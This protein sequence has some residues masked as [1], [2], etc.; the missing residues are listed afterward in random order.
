MKKGK[1]IL[2]IL[3]F[4]IVE[5][6]VSSRVFCQQK[7]VK[8]IYQLQSIFIYNFAKLVGWPSEELQGNFIIV[9]YGNTPLTDDLMLLSKSKKIEKLTIVVKK[10]N[11][12]QLLTKCHI[13]FVSKNAMDDFDLIK[14]KVGYQNTLIVTE[15]EGA[16]KKGAAINFVLQNNRQRFE[17]SEYN[18]KK[19]GLIIGSELLK[20]SVNK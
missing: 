14:E 6:T 17:V 11:S 20:L 13:L 5:I 4:V 18:A 1:I 15:Y 16:L 12:L 8:N 2:Y 9:V 7:E 19:Y 3:L 10:A